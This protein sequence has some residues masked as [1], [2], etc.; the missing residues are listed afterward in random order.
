MGLVLE[1]L[2]LV[3]EVVLL[4]VLELLLLDLRLGGVVLLVELVDIVGK[5]LLGLLDE[6][7]ENFGVFLVG[8]IVVPRKILRD[9][10]GLGV[11][12]LLFHNWGASDS[13][14]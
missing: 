1:L 3:R 10:S 13:S 6:I 11:L 7:V 4:G 9:P 12:L 8:G 14:V 2:V 5:I